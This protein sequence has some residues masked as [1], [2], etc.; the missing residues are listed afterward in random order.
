MI[1]AVY[2]GALGCWEQVETWVHTRSD[3]E[4]THA[5]CPECLKRSLG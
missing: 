2:Y 4:F 5:I 1:A 3:A